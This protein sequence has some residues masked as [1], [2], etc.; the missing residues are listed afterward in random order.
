M[1]K[2]PKK[3]DNVV[4]NPETKKYDAFLKAYATN[5][6]APVI[7]A[8]DTVAWKQKGINKVNHTLKSKF[9]ELKEAYDKMVVEFEYNQLIFNAKFNFEPVVGEI[10]HL[11]QREN[12]E[13]FLSIIAPNQCDFNCLGS[14]YLNSNQ[15][16]EKV[17]S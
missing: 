9:L 7:T 5:V 2:E 6:G 3:P 13:H 17:T 1:K 12:G 8:N 4:Y 14:F 10:Y 11:Y 16:W 15:S